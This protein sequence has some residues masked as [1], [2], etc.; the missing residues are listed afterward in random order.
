MP[1]FGR[2][3]LTLRYQ[4]GEAENSLRHLVLCP[5]D[6]IDRA[7]G[8]QVL[9]FI[10]GFMLLNGLISQESFTRIERLVYHKMPKRITARGDMYLWLAKSWN[11][12]F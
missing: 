9:D 7:N 3:A 1:D 8:F 10:N 6:V 12:R 11:K 5:D 2:N 4:W